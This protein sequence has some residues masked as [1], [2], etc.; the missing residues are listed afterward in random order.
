MK[1][2]QKKWLPLFALVLLFSISHFLLASFKAYLY[3]NIPELCLLW[4]NAI[5]LKSLIYLKKKTSTFNEVSELRT[6]KLFQCWLECW[7]RLHGEC[8]IDIF[9]IKR[10]Y[11]LTCFRDVCSKKSASRKMLSFLFHPFISC[12]LHLTLSW[13]KTN[14][15][16][17]KSRT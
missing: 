17:D 11:Y 13:Y 4:I 9:L 7:Q 10:T 1:L 3:K 5:A 8:S 6:E 16:A 2:N 12:R 14:K 15:N